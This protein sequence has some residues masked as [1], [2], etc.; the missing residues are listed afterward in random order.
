MNFSIFINLI[1]FLC[2][3]FRVSHNQG[4]LDILL[5]LYPHTG[6]NFETR[7]G[8]SIILSGITHEH[9]ARM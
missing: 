7:V 1:Q 3:Y 9:I 5:M 6:V 8:T 2:L 4:A